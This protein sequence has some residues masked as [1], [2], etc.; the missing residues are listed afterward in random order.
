[1]PRDCPTCSNALRGD[2]CPACGWSERPAVSAA[3]DPQWR[4][5]KHDDRGLRCA[6]LGTVSHDTSG[7][8]G[9]GKW[10]RAWFCFA[11][12]F[13]GQASINGDR[14]PPPRGFRAIKEVL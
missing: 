6:R 14:T 8:A 7:P 9:D 13:P 11:H 5:C 4:L 1:M 3:F 2:S 12:A 10:R